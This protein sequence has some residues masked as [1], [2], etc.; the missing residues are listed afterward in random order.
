MAVV[1]ERLIHHRKLMC[2]QTRFRLVVLACRNPVQTF[3]G[4]KRYR[5]HPILLMTCF[6]R[7]RHR[8]PRIEAEVPELLRSLNL[9]TI[10][11]DF[12]QVLKSA[13]LIL[14]SQ[15]FILEHRRCLQFIVVVQKSYFTN[16]TFLLLQTQILPIHEIY[17]SYL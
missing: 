9:L 12:L 11:I 2:F 4:L 7:S 17:R 16:Q 13:W 10:Q 5:N 1:E 8:N 15:S 3:I 14:R 6:G